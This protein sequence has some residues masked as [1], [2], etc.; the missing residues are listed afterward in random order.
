MSLRNRFKSQQVTNI[1]PTGNLKNAVSPYVMEP[2]NNEQRDRE[3]SAF[4]DSVPTIYKDAYNKSIEGMMHQMMTGKK[5][6]E[7]LVHSPFV[8]TL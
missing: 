2:E 6:Y 7:K 4:W 8:Y 3:R 5:Y 1:E